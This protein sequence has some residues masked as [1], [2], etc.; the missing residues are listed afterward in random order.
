MI[1]SDMHIHTLYSHGECTV[2]EVA[3]AA[4]KFGLERIAISEH[5]TA[6][7]FYGLKH[8]EFLKLFSEIDAL[9][10]EFSVQGLSLLKGAEVNLMG[11]GRIDIPV[12]VDLDVIVLGYHR[13]ILPKNR[14]ARRALLEAMGMGG[15]A[16]YNTREYIRAIKENRVDIIA[17]PGEY[18]S[19]DIKPLARAAAEENVLL[20]INNRHVTM[21]SDELRMAADCGA[22]FIVSSDAHKR[23]ELCQYKN[24]VDA[25]KKAGIEDAIV[26]LKK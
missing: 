22:K 26:N 12:G 6:N 4:V 13:G 15:D 25:I 7:M 9:K 21:T 16:L 5:S 2:R 20:E 17:H 19:V 11:D 18:I 10:D 24:A 14:F 3:E 1:N 8:D 23:S